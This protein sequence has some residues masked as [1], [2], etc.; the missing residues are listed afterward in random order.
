MDIIRKQRP[1]DEKRKMLQSP[2]HC[3]Y[4]LMVVV[5]QP[6]VMKTTDI[7]SFTKLYR[8]ICAICSFS[9]YIA[10]IQQLYALAMTRLATNEDKAATLSRNFARNKSVLH[11]Q[12]SIDWN[13]DQLKFGIFFFRPTTC[14]NRF[15]NWCHRR[16]VKHT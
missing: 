13:C 16:N 5:L 3:C 2:S 10:Y 6:F 8:I 9:I 1:H 15:D 12:F 11:V 7:K 4:C 14:W